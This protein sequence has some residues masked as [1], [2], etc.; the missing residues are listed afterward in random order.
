MYFPDLT[1]YQYGNGFQFEEPGYPRVHIGW[2]DSAHSFPTAEPSLELLKALYRLIQHPARI[3]R[4]FHSCPFCDGAEGCAEVDVMG[5]SII[6]SA[7]ILIAHYVEVH[8]YCPPIEFT[9]AAIR[10]TQKASRD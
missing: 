10:Q 9:H 8:E 3:A 5:D 7:P 1:P 6:Y 4:G 2:L